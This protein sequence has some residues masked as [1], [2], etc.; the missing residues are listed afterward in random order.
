MCMYIFF[1]LNDERAWCA[2]VV[3]LKAVAVA[4]HTKLPEEGKKI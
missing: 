4:V 3:Q 1:T 2:D